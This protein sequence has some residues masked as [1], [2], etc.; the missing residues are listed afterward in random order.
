VQ[1]HDVGDAE[2]AV[3]QAWAAYGDPRSITTIRETS[4]SVSTNRVFRVGLDDDSHIVSKVS[5]YGSYFLFAEDHDRLYRCTQQL[6]DTRFSGLLAN[7]LGRDGRAFTW[8][9]GRRWAV[10]YEEVR[11]GAQLPKILTEAQ[12]DRF[13]SE[14][15]ELHLVCAAIAP[16]IP[17]LS[18]SMKSNAIELLDLLASPFAPRNFDLPPEQIGT[19]WR[20]T[21]DLL[22]HLEELHYDEWPKMPVLVDWNLGN[23][24]VCF[25]GDDQADFRLDT[26]WDYDWFRI[27]SRLVDFYFLSR[28][29]SR[30]GDRTVFTYQAHTLVEPRFVRF[31]QRYHQVYP[32]TETEIR[33]LPEAYRFFLLNYV[34]RVGNKFFQPDLCERFRRDTA[35]WYLPELERL[36]ITPLLRAVGA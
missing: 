4:S 8:Y 19:L 26:R 35:R 5:A 6:A 12:V 29:S 16:A 7:V 1:H 10:F 36:D 22:L 24:S 11:R 25:D 32:L 2:E 28:V 18:Y 13:A 17:P 21:H 30:T 23:F 34:V 15:A 33:F 14:I 27:E 31:V 9:D 3:R 20:H